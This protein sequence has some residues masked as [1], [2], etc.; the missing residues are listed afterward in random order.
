MGY[1]TSFLVVMV[2][3]LGIAGCEGAIGPSEGVR[4]NDPSNPGGSDFPVD[5]SRPAL[6]SC[7]AFEPAAPFVYASKIKTLLTGLGL[8][9]EELDALSLNPDAGLNIAEY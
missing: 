8:T 9:D 3:A 1:R 6:S 4:G 5:T 7:D 2:L